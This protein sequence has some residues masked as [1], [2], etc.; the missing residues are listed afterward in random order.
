M[1]HLHG[2]SPQ[3]ITKSLKHYNLA[4]DLMQTRQQES[5]ICKSLFKG[6]TKL[7]TEWFKIYKKYSQENQGAYEKIGEPGIFIEFILTALSDKEC[8]VFLKSKEFHNFVGFQPN[9]FDYNILHRNDYDRKRA[10]EP[11]VEKEASEKHRK[12]QNAFKRFKDESTVENQK[13]VMKKMGYLLDVVR[14]NIAYSGKTPFNSNLKKWEYD[15]AISHVVIALQL[16]LFNMLLDNPA[17]KLFV[18]SS[19]ESEQMKHQIISDL[20]GTWTKC[21][22][23][24]S[25]INAHRSH[26]FHPDINGEDI[27]AQFFTATRLPKK[28][29]LL[30]CFEGSSSKRHLITGKLQNGQFVVANIYVKPN[31]YMV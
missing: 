18:W 16:R 30:D 28:W 29:K 11:Q 22:I 10:I 20:P 8:N 19:L 21:I 3:N 7:Q 17:E 27:N 2:L 23:N 13:V 24:G 1:S 26:F 5:E 6:L 15:E 9:I 25:I 12:L 31:L 4:M 14:L